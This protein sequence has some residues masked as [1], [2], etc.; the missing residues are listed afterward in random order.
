M[1]LP[2][3]MDNNRPKTEN[4]QEFRISIN[5][6]GCFVVTTYGTAAKEPARMALKHTQHT[7]IGYCDLSAQS[8]TSKNVCS[9]L[10]K[11]E[12]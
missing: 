2:N 8:D 6:F 5:V 4:K 10:S 11:S 12:Q 7:R 9:L 1:K 3:G